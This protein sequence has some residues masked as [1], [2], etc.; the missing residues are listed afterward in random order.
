MDNSFLKEAGPIFNAMQQQQF[1]QQN[2]QSAGS[3]PGQMQQFYASGVG[4]DPSGM[5]GSVTHP[6]Y[7][8]SIMS[9]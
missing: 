6:S 5:L 4:G 9:Q 3:F 8:Q 2:H 1:Q 7:Y